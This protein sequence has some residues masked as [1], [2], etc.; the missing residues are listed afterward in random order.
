M[1][2]LS[3]DGHRKKTCRFT[4]PQRLIALKDRYDPTNLF[5]FNRNIPPSSATPYVA[6]RDKAFPV[7][8]A[9]R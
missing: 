8:E 2:A 1:F 4:P 3:W 5:R 7:G 6:K 9:G